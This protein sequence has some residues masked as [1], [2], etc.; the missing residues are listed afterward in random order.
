VEGRF[1]LV[2]SAD[3]S[4]GGPTYECVTCSKRFPTEQGVRTHVYTIHVLPES[5]SQNLSTTIGQSTS[6]P[7]EL[8]TCEE[9]LNAL[10]PKKKQQL[11]EAVL[12][13]DSERLNDTE[14]VCTDCDR[15]FQNLEALA[16]HRLAK[17]M[18]S[19]SSSTAP[20]HTNGTTSSFASEQADVDNCNE[21]CEIC[22]WK[23][24]SLQDRQDHH[25]LFA[26][27]DL[28]FDTE[29]ELCRRRFANQRSFSQHRQVCQLLHSPR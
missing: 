3:L 29:C 1:K 5:S 28:L 9:S 2:D 13:L 24:H 20:P 21:E 25:S 23:L 22:G 12:S 27:R 4:A 10:R 14:L 15:S 19:S 26:P 11:C 16:Q 17:H 7:D 6:K 8:E 18:P